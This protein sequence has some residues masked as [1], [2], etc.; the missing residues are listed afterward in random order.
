MAIFSEI[1]RLRSVLV[2]RPGA[3]VEAMTPSTAQELLYNDIVPVAEV[4]REHDELRAVLSVVAET[5]E[6]DDVLRDL[7]A[8]R[9]GLH[10]LATALSGGD[11]R[12]CDELL[13]R[14][15][16][17]TPEEIVGDCVRG[18]RREPRRL[19]EAVAGRSFAVPPLPNL[20]FTRDTSFVVFERAFRSAMASPVRSSESALVA[21][22]LKSM[23]LTVDEA[24][25]HV[26][27]DG[28]HTGAARLGDPDAFKVE[29]G[30]VLVL[31]DD[32]ILLGLGERSS[33]A[34]LDRLIQSIAAERERPLTVFVVLLPLRR[35]TIHLDMIVTAVDREELLGFPPLLEGPYAASVY[36]LTVE[37][38]SDTWTIRDYPDTVTALADIGRRVDVIPCGGGDPV[39]RE[40]EQWF[41][42]CNSVALGPGKIV[43][44]DNNPATLDALAAAGY[45]IRR[46]DDLLRSPSIILDEAGHLRPGKVVVTVEGV[47]LAR[48]GGGPRC[49]TMP[50][51]RE[52]I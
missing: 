31:D 38:A 48:G 32:T 8:E 41:S 18:Y 7:A 13:I 12:L 21:H 6:I 17:S 35:A 5:V 45:E 11:S 50:L 40:R 47:E 34:G 51:H 24:L 28:R 10:P 26:E 49:M 20:Y 29:G 52:P 14:W 4:Q 2:H 15:R 22:V 37:P 42:A 25:A 9:D 23:G 16:D 33:A 46:S 39:I 1:G 36:R 44:Y 19:T 27:G 30:D 43:M 3:E